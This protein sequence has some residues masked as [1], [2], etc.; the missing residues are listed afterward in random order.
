MFFLIKLL[1]W[2]DLPG[3]CRAEEKPRSG[4]ALSGL[5]NNDN[6]E[7][8]KLRPWKSDWIRK[9][10]NYPRSV[11]VISEPVLDIP[12]A[13]SSKDALRQAAFR[14]IVIVGC[15]NGKVTFFSSEK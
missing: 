10:S 8:E 11:L 7:E 13:T 12:S 15:A 14:P 1:E 3:N 9:V 5:R 4:V 2:E 6:V